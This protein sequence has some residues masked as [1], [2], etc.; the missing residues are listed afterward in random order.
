MRGRSGRR[1]CSVPKL[2]SAL[3]ESRHASYEGLI[4]MHRNDEIG[5]ATTSL[6]LL[7]RLPGTKPISILTNGSMC[8]RALPCRR[9]ATVGTAFPRFRFR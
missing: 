7:R 5:G 4:G 2:C 6:G 1:A 8:C 3:N 9:L